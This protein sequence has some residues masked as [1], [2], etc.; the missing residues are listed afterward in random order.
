MVHFKNVLL[1]VFWIQLNLIPVVISARNIRIQSKVTNMPGKQ[2]AVKAICKNLNASPPLRRP[3]KQVKPIISKG[4]PK[5]VLSKLSI[6]GANV[7]KCP[8]EALY[9]I[10]N[11]QF[12]DE[13]W[14]IFEAFAESAH[15]N[16]FISVLFGPTQ[17]VRST[18]IVPPDSL[19]PA[20][21]V[22]ASSIR[23]HYAELDVSAFAGG[24]V[25]AIPKPSAFPML[26]RFNTTKLTLSK[27]FERIQN[28][29]H[30][31]YPVITAL[32]PGSYICTVPYHWNNF[33]LLISVFKPAQATMRG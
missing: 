16:P 33:V 3:S 5:K 13:A 8:G 29:N 31:K 21:I 22:E 23:S 28:P 20:I 10:E 7:T 26:Q 2:N 6:A 17:D 27:L 12:G 4:I 19:V 9:L 15:N 1:L 11:I 30:P 24:V 25:P 18:C 32:P 14:K